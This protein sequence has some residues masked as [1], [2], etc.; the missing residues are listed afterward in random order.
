MDI[1]TRQ[2]TIIKVIGAV[3]TAILG[4]LTLVFFQYWSYLLLVLLITI[5]GL[6]NYYQ[7]L[8]MAKQRKLPLSNQTGIPS[9]QDN[10]SREELVQ[11][12]KE[13]EELIEENESLRKQLDELRKEID[14]RDTSWRTIKEVELILDQKQ[15]VSIQNLKKGDTFRISIE[16]SK[17]FTSFLTKAP[18][19]NR[20]DAILICPEAK[21][22]K[23]EIAIPKDGDFNLVIDSYGASPFSVTVKVDKRKTYPVIV[24]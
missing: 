17:R 15:V 8:E 7:H 14:H 12:L 10:G 21:R 1:E 20:K 22:W 4:I 6:Y 3:S 9:V 16:G 2:G 23:D 13:S 5:S 11:A 18:S 19:Q 24:R